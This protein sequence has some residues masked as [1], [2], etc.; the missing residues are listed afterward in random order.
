MNANERC[1][2]TGNYSYDCNCNLCAH[3]KECNG[4]DAEDETIE[5][6]TED[7]SDTAS[8]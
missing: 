6:R 7:E 3:Q 5:E 8:N 2:R 4:S 1:F